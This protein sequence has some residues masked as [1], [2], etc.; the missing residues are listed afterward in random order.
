L[1][2]FKATLDVTHLL[3]LLKITDWHLLVCQLIHNA[4]KMSK[5]TLVLTVVC[6]KMGPIMWIHD[7]AHFL[8][9]VELL[10][11]GTS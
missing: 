8:W 6:K 1:I 2:S 4:R 11:N 10:L 5:Q 3:I 9:M 7:R